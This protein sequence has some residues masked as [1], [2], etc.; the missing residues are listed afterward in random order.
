MDLFIYILISIDLVYSN[1]YK[2]RKYYILCK[3]NLYKLYYNKHFLFSLLFAKKVQVFSNSLKTIKKKP[4]LIIKN[5][6]LSLKIVNKRLPLVNRQK[7]IIN[8]KKP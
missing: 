5:K 3:T 1:W 6:K 7:S 8:N 4:P 2:L